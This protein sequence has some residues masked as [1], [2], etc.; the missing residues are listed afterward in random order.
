MAVLP[1]AGRPSTVWL[2]ALGFTRRGRRP[3]MGRRRWAGGP[4]GRGMVPGDVAVRAGLG[5]PVH[6]AGRCC[7]WP[8]GA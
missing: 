6:P 1:A 5:W 8:V 7:A 2:A 4:P 3:A